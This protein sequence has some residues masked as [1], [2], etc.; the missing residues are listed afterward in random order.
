MSQTWGSSSLG[1]LFTSR[2]R[3]ALS[4]DGDSF[5]LTLAGKTASGSV[6]RLERLTV[7]PGALWATVTIN[8][9]G[10]KTINLDGIANADARRM[11][12]A[13]QAAISAVQRRERLARL[14]E[15]LKP[16]A[17]LVAAWVDQTKTSCVQQLQTRGW[18]SQEFKTEVTASRPTGLEQ[19][20]EIPG[21]EQHLR[22]LDR[23]LQDAIGFWRQ[24]FP[25]HADRLN[26][27]H[28][29]KELLDSRSFFDRVEKSPLTQE[30]AE[31]VICFDN[32]VLLVASAGSGKTSVMVAKA[33]YALQR[34][35]F[36]ADHMLLLA[37][38][39]DAAAELRQRLK[40][41]LAPLGLPADQVVAKTFHA[42][43]LEVIGAATGRK[44]SLAPWVESGRDVETLLEMV[45]ELKATD[46]VFRVQWDLFRLVFGQDLPKFGKEQE[47]P[48]GWDRQTG[49]SGFWTLN[50]EVVKSRGEM[51]IANWLFYN[52][53]RYLY[54]SPYRVDTAD[55]QHRQYQPDF[56]FPDIDAYLEHWAVDAQ[57]EPPA[58]FVGYKEGMAWKRALHQTHGT[59]LLETTMADLWSGKAFQYLES[60]LTRHGIVLDPNPDREVHGRRPIENPRMAR[61]MRS[62]LTHI[63]SN[64]LTI[65]ALRQRLKDGVAGPF[66]FR[67]AMF[68]GIAEK[69]WDKWE[70]RLRDDRCIDFEDM[71]N[72]AAD[73]IEQGRWKSPFELVMVDEF[74]D[75]SQARARL[76][77][78]LIN[79][80]GRHL[81]A[82]GDDWQSI[83]RFA[84][85]DLGVMT[86]F[87]ALFGKAVTL[88]LETTFRCPQA[89]CDISSGFVQKNPRQLQKRVRSPRNEVQKPVHIISVKDE[90]RIRAPVQTKVRQLAQEHTGTGRPLK[91]FV[92]GR[93]RRDEVYTPLIESSA[94][95]EVEFIT[96]HASKGLEADHV[97]LPRITSETMGF[98]SRVVDDPVLQL[99]MPGGDDF[100]F[101]EERRLFYVALT[102]AKQTV[103]LVTVER[104]ESPFISELVRDHG[105]KVFNAD[106]SETAYEPCTVCGAGFMVMRNG[107]YGRFYGCTNFPRCTHTKKVE[108]KAAG[109]STFPPRSNPGRR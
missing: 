103:T 105:L 39:N 18:L 68:L 47:N 37:F 33:G 3:W 67:H 80:P 41:R 46:S 84:G 38:N 70:Q 79:K 74:Q 8:R 44:P 58:E 55:A 90:N 53:V 45:D 28:L 32:R 96:V 14:A 107:R 27:H 92:L 89:L 51:F 75:A 40:A 43:G 78:G 91:I 12:G 102:R 52:G 11:Q 60:E 64:R 109:G 10:G 20:L 77:A 93:Y 83:N 25:E 1:Q 99:A 26:R 9:S 19:L 81:F 30:Q 54:E 16:Q 24:P 76:V 34:G 86:G 15:D 57:G 56:Y 65:E 88:R 59:T 2:Q 7:K 71:L 48:D 29:T 87:E 82:V 35:Y 6:L 21:M 31:A 73:C 94:G 72:Q 104:Q 62:F 95:V 23:D 69:L 13:I 66:R 17:S 108:S 5:S 50:G 61:T 63:K 49:Q 106:G 101:A 22:A 85:A 42:F 36:A 98:P 100:E 97:I 4:L